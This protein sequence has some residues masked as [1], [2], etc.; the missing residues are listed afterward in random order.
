VSAD[1]VSSVVARLIEVLEAS[2]EIYAFGGAVALAS[3][4]EPRAT[5]D[6]DIVIWVEPSRVDR[7]IDLAEAAGVRLDREEARAAALERGLIVGRLVQRIRSSFRVSFAGSEEPLE[8]RDEG[9][10]EIDAEAA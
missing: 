7:A 6:V 10:E 3:W 8:V 5:A 4:S 2:G 9:V 1:S